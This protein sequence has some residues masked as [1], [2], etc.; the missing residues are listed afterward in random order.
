MDGKAYGNV[1]FAGCVSPR[2]VLGD[3]SMNQRKIKIRKVI[4]VGKMKIC[5]A[6]GRRFEYRLA[7]PV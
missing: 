7:W 2:K 5:T 6:E 1:C 3:C 4:V